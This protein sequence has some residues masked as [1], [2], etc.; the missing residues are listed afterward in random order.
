MY[1]HTSPEFAMK[2]LLVAGL[3]KIYQFAKVF[4]NAEGSSLH[5]PEFTMLEWYQT[6]MT[7][8]EMMQET[9]DLVRAVMKN[10]IT[11]HGKTCDPHGPWE[12]ITVVDALKKYADV[13]ISGHLRDLAHVRAEAARIGVYVSPRDDWENALLKIIMDKVEPHAGAPAP[14]ILCD[15]PVSM[16]ALSRPKPEDPRFA[17]RFE[18]YVCGIEL[19]NAFGELTDVRVQYER[20]LNDVV[21]RKKTYGDDYPVDEDF[22]KALEFGLKPCSGNALGLDRLVMLATGADNIGLVQAAP[23]MPNDKEGWTAL[24]YAAAAEA[25]GLEVAEMVKDLLKS[26]ADIHKTDQNGDT[27]FNIAA[28]AS[29]VAGRWMTLHWLEGRSLKGLNERSGSHGSTLAQYAAKWLKDDEIGERI[30]TAV[31]KGM[32]TDIPNKSGWTP[33]SAA[34]AMGRVRAVEI[35]TDLYSRA[36]IEAQTLEPYTARYQGSTVTYLEGLDAVGVARARL[37]QDKGLHEEMKKNL[38]QCIEVI[39]KWK[40]R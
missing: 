28:P 12:I 26:G 34:A 18:V 37:E 7:Y 6:G 25:D 8:R 22:I 30:K 35:F 1:L 9:T 13:D 3:P 21:L 20:F 14:T 36:A 29:P 17:E 33:L 19:A 11:F 23:V 15:Y 5:S 32:K 16:A 27:P 2:K 38:Q 24:H 10:K 39:K 31:A 40:R 4:R